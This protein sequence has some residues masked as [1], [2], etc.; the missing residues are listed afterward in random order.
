MEYYKK[1]CIFATTN[2]QKIKLFIT[3]LH[4]L[5]VQKK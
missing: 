3:R 1:V 4:T 5:N 2:K